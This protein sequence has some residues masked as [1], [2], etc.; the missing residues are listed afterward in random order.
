MVACAACDF[1]ARALERLKKAVRWVWIRRRLATR[2]YSN[3]RM[4]SV[5]MLYTVF[6]TVGLGIA[7]PRAR[8]WFGAANQFLRG[9]LPLIHALKKWNPFPLLESARALPIAFGIC[10]GRRRESAHWQHAKTFLSPG[11]CSGVSPGT[12][13]AG[14]EERSDKAWTLMSLEV[15]FLSSPPGRASAAKSTELRS[16][17][18]C[19][20]LTAW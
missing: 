16:C 4:R 12:Q 13:D 18:R 8:H 20:R 19:V 6:I 5:G 11:C 14:R 7:R 9:H 2:R 1:L 10:R 17:Q 3:V 15:F